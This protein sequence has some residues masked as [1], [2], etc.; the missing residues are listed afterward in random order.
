MAVV[1]LGS[2]NGTFAINPSYPTGSNPIGVAIGD[3]NGDGVLDFATADSGGDDVS[4]HL[5]LTGV[6]AAGYS[7]VVSM[8]GKQPVGITTGDFNNDGSLDLAVVNQI[9]TTVT[10]LGGSSNGVFTPLGT[11]T[12]GYLAAQVVTADFNGDG[13]LDL[14]VTIEGGAVVLLGNGD[15]TFQTASG[16]Y[17]TNAYPYSLAVADFNGDGKVDLATADYTG[18][19][20]SILLGKGDGTFTVSRYAGGSGF[21][22][23]T[24]D[25]NGDGKAD[26][27]VVNSGSSGNLSVSLGNGDGTFATPVTYSVNSYPEYINSAD[28]NGDGYMDL[29]INGG[30]GQYVNVVLGNGDGTFQAT[31]SIGF[32]TNNPSNGFVTLGDLNGDGM[33]DVIVT[34]QTT[35][36]NGAQ[37]LLNT[38]MLPVTY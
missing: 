9:D 16:L 29:L 14:A 10:I 19:G 2:G 15:N 23:T 5:A 33:L 31:T 36:A 12:A 7:N 21:A 20:G 11:Y 8:V 25:F 32:V 26:L 30:G 3:F 18:T 24:A 28:V 38:C 37:T 1:M 27:A 13:N 6:V 4:V 22:V 34:D 35:G 17:G